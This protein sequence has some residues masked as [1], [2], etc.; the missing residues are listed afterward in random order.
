MGYALQRPV[1][2]LVHLVCKSTQGDG[3]RV[4]HGL[5]TFMRRRRRSIRIIENIAGLEMLEVSTPIIMLSNG[6]M[7]SKS[8]G[9]QPKR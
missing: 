1:S 6:M 5:L 4:A 9:N 2:K 3:W 7:E 8:S